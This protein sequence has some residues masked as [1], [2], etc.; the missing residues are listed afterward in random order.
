MLGVASCISGR[1]N[2]MYVSKRASIAAALAFPLHQLVSHSKQLHAGYMH[3][4]QTHWGLK[5]SNSLVQFSFNSNSI[6]I[7]FSLNSHSNL[8]QFSFTSPRSFWA[9]WNCC[10]SFRLFLNPPESLWVLQKVY[11]FV[12]RGHWVLQKVC[13]TLR[14]ATGPL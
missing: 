7:Q 3:C 13:K 10:M 2:V 9:S 12:S 5:T 1:Y 14:R 11:G 6:L 4:K 8:I